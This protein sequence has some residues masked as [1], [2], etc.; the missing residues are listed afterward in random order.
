M[1]NTFLV[2]GIAILTFASCK[3]DYTCACNANYTVPGFATVDSSFN[4]QYKEK[5]KTAESKCQSN[6]T[7][8]SVDFGGISYTYKVTCSLK[9]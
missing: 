8:S 7:Q 5:K 6:E 2:A 9:D 4:I 3:K 1:K